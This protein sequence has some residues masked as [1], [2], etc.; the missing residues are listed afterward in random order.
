MTLAEIQKAMEKCR[1]DAEGYLKESYT[2]GLTDARKEELDN[3]YEKAM[4]EF[5]SLKG[6]AEKLMQVA[7]LDKTI[8][9]VAGFNKPDG[10]GNDNPLP[11]VTGT[12]PDKEGEITYE[13]AFCQMLRCTEYNDR[14]TPEAR[15]VLHNGYQ[16]A[17]ADE[18]FAQSTGTASEGGYLIPE[19]FMAEVIKA[20]K[21]W[22]PME[23]AELCRHITTDSGND[24][25]WPTVDDTGKTGQDTAE[26]T[27]IGEQAFALGSNTLKAYN[28]DSGM[29]LVPWQLLEDTGVN[30]TALIGELIGE[31]MAR[32][33]NSDYTNGDGNGD[34][35]GIVVGSS[36]GVT[37]V[38]KAANGSGITKE[39]VYDLFHS[40]D[41]AYRMRPDCA[42][43]AND[44]ILAFIRKL[45][46]GANDERPL[47][48][49]GD[50]SKG[51]PDTLI[52][53]PVYTNN[54]M[55]DI[56]GGKKIMLF[57]AHKYFVIR[58]VRGM[59][60]VTLRERYADKRQNGY[61]AWCR[62]DSRL[63][64]PA[65]VKHAATAS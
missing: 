24:I 27:A 35:Q 44:S 12:P 65:A 64:I 13:Q 63:M 2:E 48:Q 42:F 36:A 31:R 47:W 41:V 21:W 15:Q 20:L 14:M 58:K 4:A 62:T 33:L 16:Q 38:A 56:G 11:D 9:K 18:H 45:G 34:P 26:N 10:G 37:A 8:D 32:R 30:L 19:G 22:G 61:F 6:Q 53:K 25:P 23:N 28:R 7:A 29:I 46:Y 52:Q 60:M 17:P 43:Q 54:A 51:F 59:H 1:A 39:M 50:I 55:D 5:D 40:V 3:S 49:M 57:G